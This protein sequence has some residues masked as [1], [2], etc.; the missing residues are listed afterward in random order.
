MQQIDPDQIARAG[1]MAR[2]GTFH[3]AALTATYHAAAEDRQSDDGRRIIHRPGVH[4][5]IEEGIRRRWY[6]DRLA[7]L[8]ALA[9]HEVNETQTPATVFDDAARA[10]YLSCYDARLERSLA[11]PSSEMTWRCDSPERAEKIMATLGAMMDAGKAAF[12]YGGGRPQGDVA[13]S[14]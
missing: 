3:N 11:P 5:P 1:A 6:S 8:H 12:P 9:G 14:T 2:W 4:A 7:E 13:C 10:F